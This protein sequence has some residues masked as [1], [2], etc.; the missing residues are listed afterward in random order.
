MRHVQRTGFS[1]LELLIV[2]GIIA[3][4]LS[5]LLP[6]ISRARELSKRVVCLSNVRQLSVAWLTYAGDNRGRFATAMMNP[7]G[8]L[9]LIQNGV[10]VRDYS[11]WLCPTKDY[12][13]IDYA[14]GRLWPYLKNRDVYWCPNDTRDRSKGNYAPLV[15]YYMNGVFGVLTIAQGSLTEGVGTMARTL[16]E[17]KHLDSTLLFIEAHYDYGLD[18]TFFWPPVYGTKNA[19]FF[20]DDSWPAHFHLIRSNAE[21]CTVSFADGHA[22]FWQY[23]PDHPNTTMLAMGTSGPTPFSN[24][25]KLQL[26]AWAGVGP[27]PPGVT[28]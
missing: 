26:G 17:F 4:L 9:G 1:L 12:R 19:G 8:E 5:I 28:P 10:S 7:Y 23:V 13:V 24:S 15:S 25:D 18:R 16:G 20:E 21:G 27:M 6:A 22:I 14:G 11:A 2:I 3:L